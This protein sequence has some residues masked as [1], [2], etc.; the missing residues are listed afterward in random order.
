MTIDPENASGSE[1]AEQDSSGESQL[2]EVL[3]LSYEMASSM[4]NRGIADP[5]IVIGMLM[6]AADITLGAEEE[7]S[8]REA[9]EN[10]K[11]FLNIAGLAYD[12]MV[13][14]PV[15]AEEK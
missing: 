9:A 8:P 10:K 7:R 15:E 2:I 1:Q 13:S 4:A 5:L 3:S 6:T 12:R 11:M 14:I